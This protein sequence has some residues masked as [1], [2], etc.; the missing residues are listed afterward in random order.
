MAHNS[1]SPPP[2]YGKYRKSP[3]SVLYK[4]SV[5]KIIQTSSGELNIPSLCGVREVDC[6][7]VLMVEV[8][9]FLSEFDDA[10]SSLA[11]EMSLCLKSQGL[12]GA[13]RALP[14]DFVEVFSFTVELFVE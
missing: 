9:V 1:A 5:E 7:V 14:G 10:D 13:L 3:S 8:R 6:S 12:I 4:I 11:I 2:L